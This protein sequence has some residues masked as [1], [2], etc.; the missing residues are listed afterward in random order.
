MIYELND[1]FIE[2][3]LDSINPNKLCIAYM[4]I[5][6]LKSNNSKYFNFHDFTI[7]ET[8]KIHNTKMDSYENYNFMSLNIVNKDDINL[9]GE[10][11]TLYM[12]HNLLIIVEEEKHMSK[13]INEVFK[14]VKMSALTLDK[15]VYLMLEHIIIED[16]EFLAKIED[17]LFKLEEEVLT[18]DV[19]DFNSKVIYYQKVLL[20]FRTY[21]AQF[22]D[23]ALELEENENDILDD[24]NLR[25]YKM[26][27]ARLTRLENKSIMIKD[28][29]TQIRE[30]YDAQV[31]INLNKTMNLFTIITSIF[32]PLTLIVGWYGM[33]FKFMPELAWE[34]GYIAVIIASVIVVAICIYYF[35]K[36][37]LM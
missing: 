7:E 36:K 9:P 26:L 6:E 12:S 22:S 33:N 35:K 15:L 30:V 24:N 10:R 5:D 32:L 4:T 20:K 17:N 19:L 13:Y 16:D 29:L 37:K 18:Q 1:E 8:Q 31:D 27:G 3:S 14:H 25:Y 23:V 21:Y 2:I 34:Y 11:A 28:Y